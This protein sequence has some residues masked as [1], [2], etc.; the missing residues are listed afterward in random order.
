MTPS[1]IAPVTLLRQTFEAAA[2]PTDGEGVSEEAR[3][4]AALCGVY[5]FVL[6]QAPPF[7]FSSALFYNQDPP[8]D[9]GPLSVHPGGHRRFTAAE[10]DDG[11]ECMLTIESI[12]D[13]SPLALVE[14]VPLDSTQRPLDF[15]ALDLDARRRTIRY[16][17]DRPAEAL[18]IRASGL[19]VVDIESVNACVWTGEMPAV[20]FAQSL[21][22]FVDR[23]QPFRIDL[24]GDPR[25]EAR[26]LQEHL[27]AALA[28]VLGTASGRDFELDVTYRFPAGGD[29]PP[30]RVPVMLATLTSNSQDLSRTVSSAL[31]KWYRATAPEKGEFVFELTIF[32]ANARKIPVLTLRQLSLPIESIADLT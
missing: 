23:R 30:L 25:A 24:L 21:S 26:T 5:E 1:P 3:L 13:E 8:L 6:Y 19:N 17:H 4:C 22:G 14:I 32:A 27:L 12:G 16:A 11:A 20:H 10:H 29:G 9:A 31:E 28:I 15:T 2:I 18:R 7:E